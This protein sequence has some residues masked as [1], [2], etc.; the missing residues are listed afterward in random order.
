[1]E[2]IKGEYL[3]DI[4]RKIYGMIENYYPKLRKTKLAYWVASNFLTMIKLFYI[5]K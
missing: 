3:E 1:M 4:E 2:K 5:S